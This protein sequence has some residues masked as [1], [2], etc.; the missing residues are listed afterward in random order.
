MIGDIVD[1]LTFVTETANTHGMGGS[2]VTK[3]GRRSREAR[4]SSHKRNPSGSSF[5]S[6]VSNRSKD[7]DVFYDAV[8]EIVVASD[9]ETSEDGY[10][11][12]LFSPLGP[13]PTS[14]SSLSSSGTLSMTRTLTKIP[15]MMTRKMGSSLQSWRGQ[16]PRPFWAYV[17]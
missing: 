5:I 3:G 13:S 11:L 12:P 2:E 8:T 4:K 17:Y 10:S 1:D 15:P 7:T 14:S 9:G 6:I 16:S